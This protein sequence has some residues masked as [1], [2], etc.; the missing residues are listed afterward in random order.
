MKTGAV[1][2]AAG[3]SSRMKAFKPMLKLRGSTVIETA[4]STLR[5]ADVCEIAVVT[6][7]N[8][9]MLEKQLAPAG[10][11]CLRNTEYETTEMFD[12]AKIGLHYLKDRCGRIFFLPGDVPLFSRRSLIAMAEEM[13][14][15]D[16]Q[17]LMPV[18]GGKMG[19]PILID[20]GAVESLVRYRGSGGLKGA[21]D[22]F[23]GLMKTV[24]LDDEGMLLDAD[25]PEDYDRLL[26]YAEKHP[27]AGSGCSKE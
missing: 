24:E 26:E 14:R 6:G 20:S 13:N 5:S 3:M 11:I 4:I 21:I 9:E 2:V 22:S 23:G 18:H 12:S 7:K 27:D 17:I 8:A 1:I 19:H 16:C 15:G 10:V 25:R